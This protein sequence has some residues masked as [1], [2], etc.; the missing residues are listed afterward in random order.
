M[1]N[2]I[3]DEYD[4]QVPGATWSNEYLCKPLVEL[5]SKYSDQKNIFEIGCGN[6]S[7]ADLLTKKGYKVT[8]IDPSSKGIEVANKFH[9]D[10]NLNVGDSY[11]DLTA[12]YG[13]YPIVI[14]LEVIEHCLYPRKYANTFCDLIADGGIGIISTPYHGY[15][16]NLLLAITGKMDL[17]YGALWDGGHIKFFSTKTLT[18]LLEETG[19]KFIKIYRVGRIPILAK[20]MI[21]I[22]KK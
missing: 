21:A 15:L 18:E 9:P 12:R 7:T 17:H 5:I 14:S 19:F 2:I 22:V 4:Y 8:G 6:G 1:D 20:S 16:K 11:D 3:S 10:I 13:K